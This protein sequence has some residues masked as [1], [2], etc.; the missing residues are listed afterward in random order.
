MLDKT[1]DEREAATDESKT[2]VLSSPLGGLGLTKEV[3]IKKAFAFLANG[4][5]L[6]EF[7]NA[8]LKSGRIS[9]MGDFTTAETGTLKVILRGGKGLGAVRGSLFKLLLRLIIGLTAQNSLG[10]GDIN[11]W[12]FVKLDDYFDITGVSKT[13]SSRDA[14]RQR[15]R[16]DI[17][18]LKQMELQWVEKGGGIGSYP[19]WGGSRIKAGAIMYKIPEELARYLMRSYLTQFPMEAFK[20]D[21]RNINALALL[22]KIMLH[23]FNDKNNIKGTAG[24]LSVRVCLESCPAIP[25]YE[26][27]MNGNRDWVGRIKE[28]L[29]NTLDSFSDILTWEYSN[30][31]GAPLTDEQLEIPNYLT[32]IS[33]FISFKIIDKPDQTERIDAKIKAR[34]IAAK[35][36][37][38]RKRTYKEKAAQKTAG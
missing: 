37:A 22:Y 1:A 7:F 27:V 32:F 10:N 28:A 35:A 11:P 26:S 23:A 31:K 21:E 38:A 17:E 24:I 29:E 13:T 20:I 6:N 9:N 12:V 18:T 5:E 33:L 19:L 30:S 14:A 8:P 34:A 25:T 4:P 36:K 3:G 15:V 16:Q 2:A